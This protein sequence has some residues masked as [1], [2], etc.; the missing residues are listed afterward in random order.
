MEEKKQTY[1]EGQ[2]KKLSTD[3]VRRCI[4]KFLCWID[5][6]AFSRTCKS[7]E[8]TCRP[9]SEDFYL[10]IE[11]ETDLERKHVENAIRQ[12]IYASGSVIHQAMYGVRYDKSKYEEEKKESKKKNYLQTDLDFYYLAMGRLDSIRQ[13]KGIVGPSACRL[14]CPDHPDFV[15]W[16]RCY[17]RRGSDK[18]LYLEDDLYENYLPLFCAKYRV[19]PMG[20]VDKL[21]P[22]NKT[23]NEA[24]NAHEAN[25]RQEQHNEQFDANTIIEVV[26]IKKKYDSL[27]EF[28]DRFVD[29]SHCK[30]YFG[31]GTGSGCTF[32]KEKVEK[33]ETKT[34][35]DSE[36]ETMVTTQ[37]TTVT[38]T[39]TR[40]KPKLH[41]KNMDHL[42]DRRFE[43]YWSL[44]RYMKQHYGWKV[45]HKIWKMKQRI[46]ESMSRRLVDRCIKYRKR[47]FTCTNKLNKKQRQD[48]PAKEVKRL[49]GDPPAQQAK[50]NKTPI[51]QLHRVYGFHNDSDDD[52][53][54]AE[55][56]SPLTPEEKDHEFVDTEDWMLK[57]QKKKE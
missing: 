19:F 15:T 30:V 55:P 27:Q 25:W 40:L 32:H 48:Y 3:V 23:D 21:K 6:F 11:Q 45:T 54:D 49:I 17:S 31:M 16:D 44:D 51:Q 33:T 10:V 22:E 13:E 34:V 7:L 37:T 2:W 42:W 26:G 46:V 9:F 1:A 20:V 24:L 29:M 53:S 8:K 41:W 56:L 5:A 57:C 50:V 47:G 39:T 4:G 18:T 35:V 38:T 52:Y 36:S 12:G 28:L 43:M 14:I